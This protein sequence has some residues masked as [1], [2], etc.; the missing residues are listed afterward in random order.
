MF[1]V[2]GLG[3]EGAEVPDLGGG[4]VFRVQGLG[5][6]GAEVPDQG[7]GR[8][9]RVRTSLQYLTCPGPW[10]LEL[11]VSRMNTF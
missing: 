2:Q 9:F 1:R 5:P 4:R 8:V 7:G 10:T 11:S 6:E 3:P